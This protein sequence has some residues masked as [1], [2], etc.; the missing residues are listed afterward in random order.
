M[1]TGESLAVAKNTH[2]KVKKE[3]P[4]VINLTA[5]LPAA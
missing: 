1:L 3:A 4:L 2:T 5:V